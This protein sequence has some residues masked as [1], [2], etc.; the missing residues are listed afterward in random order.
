MHS[1]QSR[2]FSL[3]LC[4]MERRL[5]FPVAI[6]IAVSPSKES[7]QDTHGKCCCCS[8]LPGAKV[9]YYRTFLS[10][11]FCSRDSPLKAGKA[12]S[13]CNVIP[14]P[15]FTG[16]DR[17]RRKTR[18]RRPHASTLS[19]GPASHSA[20]ACAAD[21]P[22]DWSAGSG[23]AGRSSP[24]ALIGQPGGLGARAPPRFQSLPPRRERT[25]NI[26]ALLGLADG[27]QPW[28]PLDLSPG[29]ETRR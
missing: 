7:P 10:R 6:W 11:K 28:C 24:R 21:D 22:F 2:V 5:P 20:H 8:C 19:I 17:Y 29:K 4:L 26:M 1:L 9:N 16:E 15:D 14:G 27:L 18:Q 13:E 25:G 3:L 23:W 12:R